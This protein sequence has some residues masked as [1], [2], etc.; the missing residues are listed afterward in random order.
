[1]GRLSC[2]WLWDGRS[3]QPLEGATLHIDG[4]RVVGVE[5]GEGR[6]FVMPAFVDAHCHLTQMARFAGALDLSS[7]ESAEEVLAAVAEAARKGTGIVRGERFDESGWD[8]PRLPT[9]GELDAAG[10]GRPV[11]LRR[12]CCHMALLS[13]A[14]M[15]L[16]GPNATGIDRARGVAAEAPVLEYDRR[17]PPSDDEMASSLKDAE[18]HAYACGVTGLCSM[19]RLDDARRLR[20]AGLDLDI[21]AAVLAEDF[22]EV[23][24]EDTLLGVKCFLDGSV[25]AGT[26]AMGHAYVRGGA[27]DSLL[28]G[29]GELKELLARAWRKGLPPVLH[30]IGERAVAQA[31]RCSSAAFRLVPA[32]DAAPRWARIEHAEELA[33]V[34]E[35]LDPGLHRI[36]GQPNFV[37]NWQSPEGLYGRRLGWG[38]AR[39]MNP[40]ATVTDAGLALGFGSDGMPFG[41]LAGLPGAVRHPCPEQRLG[42]GAALR[43]Y[44]TS[45][46]EISGFFGL[47]EAVAPGRQADLV[48]LSGNP[49]HTG[50]FEGIEVVAT[51]RR[52]RQVAGSERGLWA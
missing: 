44:T 9:P 41:P 33:G 27:D 49:F 15:D 48:A 18:A 25:G 45:A 28:Y 12:V 32:D 42:V 17:F 26:A 30:A 29:D 5:P 34:V 24:E 23:S 35:L 13:T 31:A 46:A 47:A 50:G 6:F 16:Y 8:D 2:R 52:G 4:G 51:L 36:C 38:A 22:D 21:S 43:A 7:A 14:M 3:P 39:G 11:F 40:F 10:G 20:R 1:M 19:E 37:V